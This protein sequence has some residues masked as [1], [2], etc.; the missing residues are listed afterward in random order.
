MLRTETNMK[1][2]IF[3]LPA[4]TLALGFAGC[5]EERLDIPQKGVVNLETFYQT[6]ADAVAA[7]TKVYAD[8]QKNFAMMEGEYNISPYDALVNFQD[9]DLWFSGSGPEDAVNAREYH[10]FRFATNNWIVESGYA[11]FYRSIQKCNLVI[12]NFTTERLGELTPTMK[13]AVA[14]ARVMRAFDHFNLAIYWGVPPI[15]KTVITAEDRP[16]NAASQEEVLKFVIE[17]I[18]AALADL[19]ERE[20]VDDQEGAYKISKGF[21]LALKG[22]AQVWLKD[23]AGAKESLKAVINSGKYALVPSEQM[24]DLLHNTAKGCSEAVFEFNIVDN[25]NLYTGYEP[26]QRG[27]WNLSN[28]FSWRGDYFYTFVKDKI[29][30]SGW[31]WTN[32]TKAF[33]D[34]LIKNDGDESYRR[35]A[36]IVRWDD[37]YKDEWKDQF[38]NADKGEVGMKPG[39]MWHACGG[40]FNFKTVVHPNQG[41]QFANFTQPARNYS[42]MRYAEVLLLYAEACAMT[43]DND[44]LKYLNAIQ[45]RAGSK[46]VS[47]SL[48][49]DEVKSEKRFELWQEGCRSV[50]LKRWGDLKTLKEAD[51]YTPS[52]GVNDAKKAVL[53]ESDADYYQKTY[54]SDLGYKDGKDEFLP[55]PFS[56]VRLNTGLKQNPG[57]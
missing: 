51:Y 41:D 33:G 11:A 38:Q 17:D 48:T 15:V 53:D 16:E 49:L 43:S 42:I 34:D 9:D 40:Y 20:S 31:G 37:L 6:D 2:S 3:L 39:Q 27:G 14:E 47:S 24:K 56:A 36:W 28:T 25:D 52:F 18:D 35:L 7:I 55:F 50:D 23:W 10:D 32:P 45:E 21:A 12:N 29:F 19:D 8:T 4:V 54:G 46:H 5:D 22:K 44:G 1:K 13:R 57:W 26:N 30:N